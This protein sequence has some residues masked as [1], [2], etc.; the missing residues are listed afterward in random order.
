MLAFP[1]NLKRYKNGVRLFQLGGVLF[2]KSLCPAQPGFLRA[3]YQAADLRV[4]KPDVVF[5]QFFHNRHG[6]VTGGKVIVRA[7]TDHAEVDKPQHG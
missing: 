1:Q 4:L 5:R 7:V 3:C 6:G 2:A